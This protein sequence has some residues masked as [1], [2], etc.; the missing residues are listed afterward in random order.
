MFED[1]VHITQRD[2]A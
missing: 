2:T 1:E